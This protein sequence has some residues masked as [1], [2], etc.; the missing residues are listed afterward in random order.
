MMSLCI[1]E[2]RAKCTDIC[3]LPSEEGVKSTDIY[4]LPSEEGV[5]STDICISTSEEKVKCYSEAFLF[6]RKEHNTPGR[7]GTLPGNIF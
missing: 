7:M 2:E 4:I 6:A 3:I 5:K 1:S